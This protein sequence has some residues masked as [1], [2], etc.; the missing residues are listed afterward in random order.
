MRTTY[1]ITEYGS[2][3]TGR[4]ID[5]YTTI[6]ASTFEQLENF[7]LSNRNKETDALE[8][9]SLSA[10]KG[11]GKVITARNYVGIITMTD[12]T[13]IEILPKIYSKVS[14]DDQKV[15]KLLIEMLKTLRNSPYKSLQT[16]NVNVEKMSIFEVF[17]RMF[18]DEVF[19]IAKRG[20]KSS[21]QTISSNENVVKGKLLFSEQVK[22]N[23]A[24]KEKA[25]VEYDE[26]NTNRPENKLIKATLLYLYRQASSIKNKTD[27]RT[28]LNIFGEVEPSVDYEGDYAK[29]CPDRNTQDYSTALL[30]SRV[31]LMG[32]SFTS[33][34]GSEVAVAL[35]FPME[36]LFESYVAVQLKKILG[37]ESFKVS[38]QDKSYHLFSYPNKKFLM[39]P[40]IA[41]T[42]KD[43][44]AIFICD[45]KWKLLADEKA[46]YGISQGDM[47]Q[48]YAY[49]KKYSAQNITLLY[50]LTEQISEGNIEFDSGDGVIVRVRFVDL[51]D[52]KNSISEV[53]KEF[54]EK[55]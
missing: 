12:G 10:K 23:Y 19:Y 8:L 44:K 16:T 45:T 55:A 13:S 3:I 6:P 52:V 41:I 1:Q 25:F 37:Y 49:Q 29:F 4:S 42:R 47:Y 11:I 40:D 38:A 5:G 30:W 39:K 32:K 15:K 7:V 48:M 51:F 33:F 22:H 31:F 27:I 46:N 2:F 54:Y 50:P 34:S 18:I 28:L 9:M 21:Y 43:D 53:A 26:F 24:H 14:A 36:T 35:L 20:L 17:I